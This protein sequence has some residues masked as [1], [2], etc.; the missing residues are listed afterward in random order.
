MKNKKKEIN[1]Q[2]EK[3]IYKSWIVSETNLKNKNEKEK[4][5]YQKLSFY[6]P[7]IIFDFNLNDSAV[8]LLS[9]HCAINKLKI[10]IY[11][12]ILTSLLTRKKERRKCLKKK[13][14]SLIS[15]SSLWILVYI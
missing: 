15:T 5:S 14:T 7:Q 10:I 12:A 11:L 9:I 3:S 13:N 2:T 4:K 8:Q 1:K 6:S